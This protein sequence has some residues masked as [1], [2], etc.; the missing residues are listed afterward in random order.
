MPSYRV[1]KFQGGLILVS[2][3]SGGF[4]G[5]ESLPM[6]VLLCAGQL[7]CYVQFWDSNGTCIASAFPANP[8]DRPLSFYDAACLAIER[9][10]LAIR[11]P[12]N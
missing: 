10:H 7:N 5:P 12:W 6:L 3:V 1:Y 9:G 11:G 4:V 2:T 8:V